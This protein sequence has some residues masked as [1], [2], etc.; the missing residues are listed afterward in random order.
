[1]TSSSTLRGMRKNRTKEEPVIIT[2]PFIQVRTETKDFLVECPYCRN[3]NPVRVHAD[4]S[5]MEVLTCRRCKKPIKLKI[6][7]SFEVE[8]EG[9][10]SSY[11]PSKRVERKKGIELQDTGENIAGSSFTVKGKC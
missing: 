4:V 11:N 1:M 8:V 6:T 7:V 2:T 9:V 5:G 10:D 3:L